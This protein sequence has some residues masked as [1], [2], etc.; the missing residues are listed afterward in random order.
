MHDSLFPILIFG[1]VVLIFLFVPLLGVNK[2]A[3]EARQRAGESQVRLQ[4]ILSR[5][6]ETQERGAES[7]ERRNAVEAELLSNQRET[8][9]LLKQILETLRKRI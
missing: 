3:K 4:E 7:Q 6:K 5:A 9:E 8:N 2:S 1:L